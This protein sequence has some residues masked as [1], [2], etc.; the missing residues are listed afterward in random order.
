MN[1]RRVVGQGLVVTLIGTG[2]VGAQTPPPLTVRANPGPNEVILFE[3]RTYT[4]A[5]LLYEAGAE[6]PDLEKLPVGRWGDRVSS[7]KVGADV[8]VVTWFLSEYQGWCQ[9]FFGANAGGTSGRYPDLGA[10][11][12]DNRIDSL[13]VFPKD[14]PDLPCL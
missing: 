1:A 6:V 8:V 12:W 5:A 13:K 7:L 14:T 3:G 11:R 10:S 4:G 9:V 2:W